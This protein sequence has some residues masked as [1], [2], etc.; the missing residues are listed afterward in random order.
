MLSGDI[1]VKT[2]YS[3]CIAS[4]TYY[5][6]FIHDIISSA[7]DVYNGLDTIIID[8]EEYKVKSKQNIG[9]GYI[10]GLES[11][12][13]ILLYQHLSL[14]A[15]FACTYGQNIKEEEPIG[16]IPPAFGKL[17][18]K[19]KRGKYLLEA[20]SRF[21]FKQDRLSED[22]MDDERIPREGT[23]AWYTYNVRAGYDPVSMLSLKF[24][25]ENILDYNYREHGS[26]INAPGRNFIFSLDFKFE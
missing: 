18:L 4:I 7:N 21:A 9:A 23:P 22:D 24:A 15:N 19:W 1:S 26:G 16:G 20:F 3:K 13:D 2:F 8:S 6:S 25:V 5:Y 14:L 11:K 10:T 12:L 17:G